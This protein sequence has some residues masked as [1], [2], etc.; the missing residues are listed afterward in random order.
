MK[1]NFHFF[2]FVVVVVI[3]YAF[4]DATK[5]TLAHHY[6]ASIFNQFNPQFWDANLSWCNKWLRCESG[7]ER[8]WGSSNMFV[9]MT[10]GWHLMKFF[11][12][13][14]LWFFPALLLTIIFDFE[15]SF[16]KK[17]WVKVVGFYVFLSVLQN[18]VFTIFYHYLLLR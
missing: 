16:L 14:L 11:I 18:V 6:G 3:I 7:Q 17:D 2:L 8:F 12:D 10:D 1:Q 15:N 5:D 13:R 9:F 4:C